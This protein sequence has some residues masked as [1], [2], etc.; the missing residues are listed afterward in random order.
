MANRR[1]APVTLS[2]G[3]KMLMVAGITLV[4]GLGL[5]ALLYRLVH[6]PHHSRPHAAA[7]RPQPATVL[8]PPPLPKPKGPAP[9][10]PA[11]TQFD[12]YTILPEIH[13]KSERALRKTPPS[14]QHVRPAPTASPRSQGATARVI[15]GRFILQAA[16]FPDVVGASRLRAELALRG[17]TSYI[18]KVSITGRG[19]FYRVRL[20]P[21]HKD[22]LGHDRKILAQLGL[23]PILLREA[24]GN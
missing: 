3:Q 23:T 2:S 9:G 17:L 20:G 8:A 7:R 12:F 4:V 1:S 19:A 21:L 24:R 11:A 18:E 13:S 10:L 6:H 16:S 14:P 15:G 22:A 5:G